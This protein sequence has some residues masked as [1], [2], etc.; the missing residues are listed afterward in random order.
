MVE[1]IYVLDET[2]QV[3]FVNPAAESLL[4]LSSHDIVGKR[5]EHFV[6]FQQFMN[7]Q[8]LFVSSTASEAIER[9][10]RFHERR[11]LE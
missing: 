4:G 7:G 11:A 6:E 8:L 1:A 2:G 5:I 3:T 10:A 9:G